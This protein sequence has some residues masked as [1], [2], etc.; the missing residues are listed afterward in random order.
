MIR[1]NIRSGKAIYLVSNH[2]GVAGGVMKVKRGRELQKPWQEKH[3]IHN[4]QFD[5]IIYLHYTEAKF[6]RRT[7]HEPNRMQ[8]RKILCFPSLAFDSAHV[9]YGTGSPHIRLEDE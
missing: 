4:I 2:H 1:W 5:S 9:K 6:R 8:M 7:S 3:L